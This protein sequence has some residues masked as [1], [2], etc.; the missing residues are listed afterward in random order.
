MSLASRIPAAQLSLNRVHARSLVP[1]RQRRVDGEMLLSNDFGD[2]VFVSDE[3]FVRLV[4]GRFERGDTLWNKVSTANFLVETLDRD[5]ITARLRENLRFANYGPN[6]HIFITT[7][8][9]NHSCRYCH[10]SRAPMN[11]IETDMSP[12]TAERAVDFAFESTS[13]WLTFEFQGGEPLANWPVVEHIVEYS[14]QKNAL[15]NKSLMFALVTNLSLMTDDKLDYLIDRKVQICT[16]LDGPALLH[17]DNRQ[18]KEGAS[19]ETVLAGIKKINERYIAMGLDPSLYKVEA[20]P[21]VTRETLSQPE[22]LI[23]HYIE[24]GCRSIFLRHLDPFGFAKTARKRL[25]YDMSEFLVFYSQALDHIVALNR[26]GTDFVERTAA[27]F[28]TKILGLAEPNFLDIRSPCGA[29]I[30]QIA[31]NHD[32]RMFTCDEGRM[33]DHS[34]DDTFQ[35]G[36]CG[37]DNYRDVLSSPT[38]RA[39]TLASTLDGQ[40]GCSSCTYKPWC[41]ICPVH[42]YTEQG[43]IQGR[44]ADSTW[45]QKHMG[46]LDLLMTRIHRADAFELELF[47]RWATPRSQ[48]YFVQDDKA[49]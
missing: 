29:G 26:A 20:L 17:N 2:H 10:A 16:S 25:G 38:V 36:T 32:G 30:G 41:G 33:L 5:G 48:D 40:P 3:D 21:T 43:S 37:K 42:N 24:V 28:L 8:R 44:M 45:C 4:E 12:E 1:F 34:G 7:L 35:I 27:V 31:Y 6:L 22:A 19:H 14:R 13:P 39:M 15:A 47:R 11:A 18:W 23:D 46:I 9:C 49:L